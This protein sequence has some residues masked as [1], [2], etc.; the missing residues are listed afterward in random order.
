MKKSIL[1]A[2]SNIRKAK[3]QTLAMTVL[4]LLAAAMLNLWLM[5]S[6]DY[7][8]NFDRYH[9]KLNAEHVVVEL[10]SNNRG[11]QDDISRMLEDDPRTT[12]YTIEDALL[13]LGLFEYNGGE[14]STNLIFME[15]ESA[16]NRPIGKIEIVEDSEFTSGVYVPMLY[17][18]SILLGDTIEITLGSNVVSYQVCGY[19]NSLMMGTHNCG[20][21]V[22]VLT[23]DRYEEL[24]EQE[25]I[26]QGTVVSV[27]IDDKTESTD[28]E[29]WLKNEISSQYPQILGISN[30]YNMVS[31]SRYISQM[32]CQGVIITMAF[33]VTLIILI[34]IA[35]NVINYIQ[36]NMRNLGILKAVGYKSGQIILALLLQFA[37]ITVIT[38]VIGVGLSYCLFPAVNAMMM[39]QTGIPY[40]MRFLPIPFVVTVVLLSGAVMLAVWLAA[41]RIKGI[42]PISALRL[43]VQTHNF[44]NNHIPLE[45][46]KAPLQLALALKATFTGVKQ[47]VTVSIT[48]LILSLILVF[49]GT[50]V[51]NV[52]VDTQPFI[53]MIVG[54]AAESGINI[55]TEI[56]EAF[57]QAMHNDERVKK[58]Y[59]YHYEEVSHV[60]GVTL[61]AMVIDDCAKLNNQDICIEG[62]F[63]KYDNEMAIAA[64]YAEENDLKV[65]DEITLT[66]DGKEA[67]YIITG[68][69][70][71][72]NY[73]GKDCIMT[74]QGFER[75]GVLQNVTFYLNMDSDVDIDAFHSEINEQFGNDVNATV[76]GQSTLST[77]A[78]VYVMI[79]TVI[80]I[81]ILILSAVVIVFVLYLLVRTMLNNKKQDFGVMKAL[82]FT[83]RQLILQTALSFM[84]AVILSTVVGIIVSSLTINPLMSIMLSGIGIVKPTFTV[85]VTLNAVA[86]IGLVL[87]TFI[88]ACLLS[89]KIR[90]VEPKTLL[91]GE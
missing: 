64:K 40:E 81:A 37:G 24:K 43:G 86:G 30:S 8:Q 67:D 23:D 5:L 56:E 47:N 25:I 90:K 45:K 16:L 79:M 89:L 3:G 12:E 10:Y 42:E 26:P 35:S 72:S 87:L 65:G 80:V 20:L 13:S 4:I 85:S 77:A 57:L 53:N 31:T 55:N 19:T 52:I 46:T 14:I 6:M 29:T 71:I 36:E 7:K 17:S 75:M 62:R 38:A 48:M 66:A 21:T 9:D 39:S 15:K 70:Q 68:F 27:R 32:I 49:S 50:M 44:R 69:T 73:L 88:I 33:L 78:G 34:V 60:N 51:K 54:E 28:F 58:V 2:R 18:N 82:G 76:N 84:P 91:V 83:S 22:F 63:P 11:M 59:L 61:S 74:R 1:I 41:H